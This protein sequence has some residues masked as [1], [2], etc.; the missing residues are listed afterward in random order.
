MRVS[1]PRGRTIATVACLAIGISGLGN[2]AAA[3]AARNCPLL[4]A[5]CVTTPYRNGPLGKG[6]GGTGLYLKG[7]HGQGGT[8]LMIT[9]YQGA[10]EV[11]VSGGALYVAVKDHWL[12]NGICLDYALKANRCITWR[13]MGWLRRA[14]RRHPGF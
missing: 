6:S 1:R 4:A 3:N 9:D 8:P 7:S 5:Y 11:W 2:F 14:S 13:I 12:G 10:P